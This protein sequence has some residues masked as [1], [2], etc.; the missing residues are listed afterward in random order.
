[1]DCNAGCRPESMEIR[2]EALAEMPRALARRL[3]RWM[4][5]ELDPG[6]LP[7]NV[8]FGAAFEHI[9]RI[10]DLARATGGNGG[11]TLPGLEASRSCDWIRVVPMVPGGESRRM[12]VEG[13]AEGIDPET[14]DVAGGGPGIYP[15]PDGKSLIRLALKGH[16]PEANAC[17]TLGLDLSGWASSDPSAH[18]FA[19]R[20][21]MP[22]DGYQ[23]VG[24]SRRWKVKELFD[25]ARVPS[26][27]RDKWPILIMDGQIVWVRQFGLIDAASI[28]QS[29]RALDSSGSGQGRWLWITESF[30]NTPPNTP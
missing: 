18:R 29:S 12:P 6:N 24:K 14:T 21:W 22:G 20:A 2:V 4:V 10:V 25:R 1:M 9:E 28:G 27:K 3:V 5:A 17:A 26:W 23:P 11:V 16:P 15:A 13:P 8:R 30:P 7:E 19:V